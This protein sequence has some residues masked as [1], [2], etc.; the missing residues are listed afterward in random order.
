[1][2]ASTI[3]SVCVA[4]FL[5][6]LIILW[7]LIARLRR[8]LRESVE[9]VLP[10]AL[11]QRVEFVMPGEKCLHIEGPL[12]TTAFAGLS[13]LLHDS[14]TGLPIPLRRVLLRSS[15]RGLRRARLLL[16]RCNIDH[17]GNHDLT[18]TGMREDR[19]YSDCRIIFTRPDV[20]RMAIVVMGLVLAGLLLIFSLVFGLLAYAW[21]IQPG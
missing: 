4:G 7:R 6:G 3:T 8:V 13:F 19:N 18:T 11:R 1:M 15:V 21:Q 12:F 9:L 10:L 2:G 16:Y 20:A 17:A 5:V 14:A